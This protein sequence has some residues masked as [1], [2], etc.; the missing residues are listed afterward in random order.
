MRLS[1]RCGAV[2]VFALWVL[3]FLTVIAVSVAS[4]VRQKIILIGRLDE[5]QRTVALQQAGVRYAIALIRKSFGN[6]GG[7][8][9]VD[10][11]QQLHRQEALL[12]DIRLKEDQVSVE[13]PAIDDSKDGRF[14]VVDEESKINL[15][16]VKPEVL[17]RLVEQVLNLKPDQARQLTAALL[18]WRQT[19]SSEVKGFFSDEYYRNLR[20]PFPKK[21]SS[22]ENL[23]EVLLVEGMSRERFDQLCPYITVWGDGQIN[24]NTA[25]REVLE[26][27]GM[28]AELI[29]KIL[30]VRRGKDGIE[31]TGDDHVFLRAFDIAIELTTLT[32]LDAALIKEID[33]LNAQGFLTTNAYYFTIT[34]KGHLANGKKT[35]SA[36]AV[37]GFKE[38]RILWWREK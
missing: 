32:N 5:R 10:L 22:Y 36:K 18:D 17:Q 2:L 27:I 34:T 26:A 1:S 23:D 25:S 9:T 21:D 11:K 13:I 38:D 3:T 8:Y 16:T 28:S 6:S 15:N 37:Y 31:A 19:G 12:H 35:P 4:T 30:E 24:I 33:F 14:G 7:I 20:T 29:D